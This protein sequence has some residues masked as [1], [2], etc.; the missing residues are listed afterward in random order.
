MVTPKH[1]TASTT[2]KTSETVVTVN[3][4]I[5]GKGDSSINTD[6][7]FLNH[8]ITSFS[9][10]S[11][12]DITIDANSK[13]GIAHHLI[14]DIAITLGD[15]INKALDDRNA[16]TRF[17]NKSAPMDESL[18]VASVDLIKRQFCAVSLGIQGSSIEG[19]SRQ[20]LEHFFDSLLKSM[21]CCAHITVTCGDN[22]HHRVE[23]AIK[24]LA[25]AFREAVSH[26]TRRVG[27]PSSKGTM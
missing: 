18:A 5:D 4:N 20:D 26:D 1:R 3:L 12:V 13:D 15:T 10:H 8:L 23:A 16:I 21:T 11:L 27:P 25:L 14:E 7:T 19:V 2:R 9:K 22:D 24:A 17:G 6:N